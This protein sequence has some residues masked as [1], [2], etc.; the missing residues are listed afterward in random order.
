MPLDCMPP[1]SLVHD[2]FWV[3]C[4]ILVTLRYILLYIDLSS[5]RYLLYICNVHIAIGIYI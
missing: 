1:Q 5:H 3:M 2:R 4:N